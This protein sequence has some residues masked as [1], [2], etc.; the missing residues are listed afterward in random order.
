M[1]SNYTLDDAG[2]L[3]PEGLISLFK[4]NLSQVPLKGS[5]LRHDLQNR[6]KKRITTGKK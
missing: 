3:F 5:D 4:E 1:T 2:T 6:I